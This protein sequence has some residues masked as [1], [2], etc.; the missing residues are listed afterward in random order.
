MDNDEFGE[1]LQRT[2]SN[3]RIGNFGDTVKEYNN[4]LTTLVESKSPKVTRKVKI[5]ENAPWFDAEYRE[6]RKERRRAEKR[7]KRT[8]DQDD[9]NSF[10][11]L[12]KKTT[13]QAKEKRQQY[14]ITQIKEADNKPKKLFNVVK[15]LMNAHKVSILPTSTS[16]TQL[17]N[18]FLTYFKEKIAKIRK[19][20]PPHKANSP[21]PDLGIQHMFSTFEPATEEEIREIVKS[22]GVNCSPEDPIPIGILKDHTDTLIPYWLELV[23]L[24]L[25]TGS[26]E[27]IKSAVIGLLL[28][29]ATDVVDAKVYK[30]F[31]KLGSMPLI[32]H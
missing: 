14:Y 13:L 7:Y 24:S 18:D 30:H 6:L 26:M 5:V 22:F 23:N 28:K 4:S 11:E 9:L 15:T 27:S 12:R 1:A 8:G 17:A 19:A 10:K 2:L 3:L 21:P 32:R 16:D 31:R 25:S 20:F 29:E